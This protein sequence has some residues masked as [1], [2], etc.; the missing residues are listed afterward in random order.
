MNW[1]L[2]FWVGN[3]ASPLTVSSVGWLNATSGCGLTIGNA[4]VS[5]NPGGN[6]SIGSTEFGIPGGKAKLDYYAGIDSGPNGI[7]PNAGVKEVVVFP[8]TGAYGFG[9]TQNLR[10][11]KSI[12]NEDIAGG[13]ALAA[14]P[15]YFASRGLSLG[16]GLSPEPAPIGMIPLFIPNQDEWY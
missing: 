2:S 15:I 11:S 1:N 3:P 6:A 9:I 12:S 4:S 5:C 13:A 7:N 16:G 14:L 10:V 8:G